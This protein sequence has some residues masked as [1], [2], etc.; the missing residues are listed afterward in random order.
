[1][2]NARRNIRSNNQQYEHFKKERERKMNTS[3]EKQIL[4]IPV[5]TDLETSGTILNAPTI[6]LSR[7]QRGDRERA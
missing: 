1:M 2:R 3:R 6:A 7:S 4:E 5:R